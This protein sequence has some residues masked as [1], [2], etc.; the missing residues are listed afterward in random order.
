MPAYN[1]AVCPRCTHLAE[2]KRLELEQQFAEGYGKLPEGAYLEL[3][4]RLREPLKIATSL[5]EDY[6]GGPWLDDEGIFHIRYAAYC[7][8]C[9]FSFE[10]KFEQVAFSPKTEEE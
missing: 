9:G 10:F 4:D 3:R 8:V 5:R 2:K 7:R 1:W 6:G